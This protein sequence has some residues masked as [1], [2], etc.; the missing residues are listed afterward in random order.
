M[1]M[2]VFGGDEVAHDHATEVE[3]G[4]EGLGAL[5]GPKAG[6]QRRETED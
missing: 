4:C 1:R 3:G 2:A 5:A 6:E